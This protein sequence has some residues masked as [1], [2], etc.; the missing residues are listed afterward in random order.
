MPLDWSVATILL[1][2]S[3][4]TLETGDF[5]IGK[6]GF[7][8]HKRSKRC[9][10]CCPVLGGHFHYKIG[11]KWPFLSKI[12]ATDRSR[13]LYIYIYMSMF[14]TL[15]PMLAW[16]GERKQTRPPPQHC[17]NCCCLGGAWFA[18]LGRIWVPNALAPDPFCI[19]F[20]IGEEIAVIDFCQW[21]ND[22]QTCG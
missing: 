14:C 3:V 1:R 5:L 7:E 12:V 9:T 4:P 8:E 21:S 13:A 11:Q 20:L 19:A 10:K 17:S 22:Y 2:Y 15:W 6:R 18:W 16:L